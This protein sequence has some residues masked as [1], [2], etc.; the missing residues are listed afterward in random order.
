MNRVPTRRPDPRA[1]RDKRQPRGAAPL[2][3]RHLVW[4]YGLMG[5]AGF[6]FGLISPRRPFGEDILAH[7]LIVFGA[8]AGMA[9]LALR[10]V[11]RRPVPELI[12]DRALLFGIAA[13]VAM[14]LAG[15]FVA[16]YLGRM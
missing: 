7:P 8:A 2:M 14:F 16:V 3:S 10:V 5:L 13:G 6:G 11:L 12:P 15:N 9:L 1:R 4:W